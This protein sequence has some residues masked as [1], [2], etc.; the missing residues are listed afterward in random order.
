PYLKKLRKHLLSVG[1][2]AVVLWNGTNDRN[3]ASKLVALGRA[4]R[5]DKA[6]LRRGRQ[7]EGHENSAELH[8]A[9]PG[10]YS[11]YTGYALSN[12]GIWRP[13]SWAHDG[14]KRQIIETTERRAVY[15]GLVR[16]ERQKPCEK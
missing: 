9:D 8:R 14:V 6:I 10:R 2:I 3:V 11:V 15:F 5:G 16:F 4:Q 12:D 7:S 1:G 13:H